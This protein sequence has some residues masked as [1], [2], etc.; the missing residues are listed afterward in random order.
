VRLSVIIPTLNEERA[1]PETLANVIMAV[2]ACEIIVADGG[3]ADGTRV[4]AE[5]FTEREVRWIDSE[6]GRGAQMNAGARAATGDVLLFLHADTQLPN[7][8][9]DMVRHA[10]QDSRVV[11]GNFKVRFEPRGPVADFYA[12]CYNARSR[13]KVFYGDSAIFV[14]RDIFEAIGGYR[15]A[16]IMED[17][18]LVRRLRRAG[19]LRTIRDGEVV[20]SARRFTNARSGLRA[21]ALWTWL[22]ILFYCGAGQEALERRYPQVR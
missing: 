5:S 12:W 22:H 2:P 10:L 9:L 4:A 13:A 3:S 1:L 21:L 6:R 14:R 7:G 8:T 16:R 20:S 17:L 19:K 11:G 15:H 18:E